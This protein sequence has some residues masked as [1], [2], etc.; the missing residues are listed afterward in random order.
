MNCSFLSYFRN[1]ETPQYGGAADIDI[2]Q[3]S[4]I[5]KG[6]SSNSTLIHLPN[7]VGTHIDFPR[8]FGKEGKTIN[9]YKADSWEFKRV[10]LMDYEAVEEEI[11]N[12]EGK[13]D[14][15]PIDTELLLI[16]TGFQKYRG[17]K[18]YWNNNPGLAPELAKSLRKQCPGLRA[19]G[20]DFISLSSYQHRPLGRVAHKEFLIENDILIIEDMDLQHLLDNIEKV[21][22]LPLMIDGVDG[23][24]ITVIAYHE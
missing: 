20:F 10:C 3:R 21:I 22:A 4:S 18:K 1:N 9:D 8:H 12:L 6:D 7:H 5:G 23:G 2:R 17:Q 11:I 24:P 19:V 14:D 16:R 15:L 13:M